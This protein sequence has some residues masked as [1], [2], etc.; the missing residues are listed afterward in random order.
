MRDGDGVLLLQAGLVLQPYL[1]TG[2]VSRIADG[3]QLPVHGL[4]E[5]LPRGMHE[6][7]R[8]NLLGLLGLAN[9][10]VDD[11]TSSLLGRL[12]RLGNEGADGARDAVVEARANVDDEVGLLDHEVGRRMTVH[13]Q[14]VKG[15]GVALVED[16]HGV[17]GGGD[18]DL[19]GLGEGLE[20]LGRVVAALPGD[21][22]GL[23]GS[24]DE[25]DH[26]RHGLGAFEVTLSCR[27]SIAILACGRA[28]DHVSLV[29]IHHKLVIRGGGRVDGLELEILV[30]ASHLEWQGLFG[31]AQAD[32]MEGLP[33]PS[34]AG[35]ADEFLLVGVIHELPR[36]FGDEVLGDDLVLQVLG[37]V[38]EHRPRPPLARDV[39]GVIHHERNF[40]GRHDLVRPLGAGL[41]HFDGRARLEGCLRGEG[42]CL[43]AKNDHWDAV[44]D[45]VG[46]GGDEVGRPRPGRGHHDASLH[47]PI[48]A[49]V[50]AL[51]EPLGDMPCR[52]LVR[53]GDPLD[54]S[55][56][57]IRAVPGVVHVELVQEGQDST[58]G[59]PVHHRN[60]VLLELLVNDGRGRLTHELLQVL[61]RRSPGHLSGQGR[62]GLVHGN[63]PIVEEDVA[64]DGGGRVAAHH[65]DVLLHRG[66]PPPSDEGPITVSRPNLGRDFSPRRG[67]NE[68]RAAGRDAPSRRGRREGRRRGGGE[69]KGEGCTW[70]LHGF[71][72]FLS[73]LPWNQN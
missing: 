10:N 45:G 28:V 8:L 66:H 33:R 29:V 4:E 64:G 53:V 58:A 11:T 61:G 22:D 5:L 62:L 25:L 6:E 37:Q 19:Q 15:E 31:V 63:E 26:L 24:L 54:G 49:Q 70:D 39:K 73:Q 7:G 50:R 72:I 27:D 68:S 38:D 43:A 52:A 44:A 65:N 9:V 14:H 35:Q 47:L 32:G 30:L 1:P 46:D 16:A 41:G 2:D 71:S 36:P 17:E 18:G 59:V 56:G 60:A 48:R 23:L 40:R 42:C 12:T 55:R 20:L 57:A 51:G 67:V 21:D 13:S 34:P 69:D 3:A